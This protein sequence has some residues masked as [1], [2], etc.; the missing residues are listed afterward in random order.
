MGWLLLFGVFFLIFFVSKR[1]NN[2][3]K[4]KL[5]SYSSKTPAKSRKKKSIK[6]Y[7]NEV[8]YLEVKGVFAERSRIKVHNQIMPGD[9]VRL[10]FEPYN[11]YDKNA[12]GVYNMKG[13]QLGFLPRNQRKVIKTLK[14]NSNYLAFIEWKSDRYSEKHNK[15]FYNVSIMAYLG[16]S[17]KGI[18]RLGEIHNMLR[19]LLKKREYGKAKIKELN[20]SYSQLKKSNPELCFQRFK[21]I[22]E[23]LLHFNEKAQV[24]IESKKEYPK[25]FEFHRLEH[26]QLRPPI[27]KLTTLAKALGHY[28]FLIEFVDRAKQ[29][30]HLQTEKQFERIIKRYDFAKSRLEEE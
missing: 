16:L 9:Q 10:E 19:D 14:E 5:N 22:S 18:K 28:D 30:P 17:D 27:D 12:I 26:F 13:D 21:D 4:K 25:I 1:Y 3:S 8:I 6:P 2:R 7:K 20:K 15:H 11:E 29:K 24:F 23:N